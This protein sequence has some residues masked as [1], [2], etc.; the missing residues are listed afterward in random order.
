MQKAALYT[1]GA[2]FAAVAVAHLVRLVAGIEIIVGDKVVP[3]HLSI[4]GA[5]IAGLLAIWML[6]AARRR[7]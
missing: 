3:V 7:R 2:I 6:V 1:S 5:I 4:F